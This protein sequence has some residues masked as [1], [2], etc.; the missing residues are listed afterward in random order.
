MLAWSVFHQPLIGPRRGA[1]VLWSVLFGAFGLVFRLGPEVVPQLLSCLGILWL[2]WSFSDLA[3]WCGFLIH[4]RLEGPVDDRSRKM[5]NGLTNE[6]NQAI[7]SEVQSVISE[8]ERFQIPRSPICTRSPALLSWRYSPL[9]TAT[10]G[11][12]VLGAAAESWRWL[13]SD[14]SSA[15]S[16]LHSMQ[17]PPGALEQVKPGQ[18]GASEVT[19]GI[20]CQILGQGHLGWYLSGPE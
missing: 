10:L 11:S 13:A 3:T 8:P 9:L 5:G 15:W 20:C 2:V 12:G 4:V 18:D 16:S 17:L 7:C 19:V 14:L 6:P 1:L